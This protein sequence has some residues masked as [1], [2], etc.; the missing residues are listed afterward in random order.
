MIPA[1]VQL[2]AEYRKAAEAAVARGDYRRAAFIYGKLLK[3]YRSAAGVLSRGNLVIENGVFIGRT[4][5]GSFIK[6]AVRS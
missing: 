2:A 3:D 6:R 1:K 4:G 5:A